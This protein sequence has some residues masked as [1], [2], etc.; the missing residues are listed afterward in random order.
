M[1]QKDVAFLDQDLLMWHEAA[2][3]FYSEA[4]IVSSRPP[5]RADLD[6]VVRST[7]KFAAEVSER[8]PIFVL[9]LF[10]LQS[11]PLD[12]GPELRMWWAHWP[13]SSRAAPP[14]QRHWAWDRQLQNTFWQPNETCR[15]PPGQKSGSLFRNSHKETNQGFN[16]FPVHITLDLQAPMCFSTL[17]MWFRMFPPN[18]R[19]HP[20]GHMSK[21]FSVEDA[22]F[23]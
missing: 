17:E 8:E 11:Y 3:G 16:A 4:F 7:S 13:R 1:Q 23:I 21:C 6:T 10:K 15:T 9:A 18:F 2:A 14:R 19:L 22:I 12:T 5:M 20:E